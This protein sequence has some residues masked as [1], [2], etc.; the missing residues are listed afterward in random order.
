MTPFSE[1][2]RL[3]LDN[4]KEVNLM[5]NELITAP[6][7]AKLMKCSVSTAYKVLA[8]I[9]REMKAEGLIVLAGRV[10]RQRFMRRVGLA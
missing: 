10:P 9:K 1:H 5:K 3:P 7:A 6:E 2:Y 8:E 4:G